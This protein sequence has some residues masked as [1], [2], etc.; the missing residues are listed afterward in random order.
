MSFRLEN[1]EILKMKEKTEKLNG[2]IE[3]VKRHF[4]SYKLIN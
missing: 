4:T 1:F 2:K 3:Q